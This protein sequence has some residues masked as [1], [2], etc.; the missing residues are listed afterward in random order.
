MGGKGREEREKSKMMGGGGKSAQTYERRW[1]TTQ[2]I[3]IPTKHSLDSASPALAA[4]QGTC[5]HRLIAR[6]LPTAVK[7][8]HQYR[9]VRDSRFKAACGYPLQE[10]MWQTPLSTEL[11]STKETFRWQLHIAPKQTGHPA[12]QQPTYLHHFCASDVP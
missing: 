1:A 7:Q 6:V 8:Q 5:R 12:L 11:S 3:H 4:L 2:F 10:H 9:T